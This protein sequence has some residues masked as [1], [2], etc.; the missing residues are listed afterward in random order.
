LSGQRLAVRD[1][2]LLL[3][4][5]RCQTGD[6][7]VGPRDLALDARTATLQQ[8]LGLLRA[9]DGRPAGQRPVRACAPGVGPQAT[10]EGRGVRGVDLDAVEVPDRAADRVGD[11]VRERLLGLVGEPVVLRAERLLEDLELALGDDLLVG[12]RQRHRAERGVLAEA[13]Q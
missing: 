8:L 2:C 3:V 9:L 10:Q 13:L 7:A 1:G 6:L 12:L 4:R 11:R 5:A